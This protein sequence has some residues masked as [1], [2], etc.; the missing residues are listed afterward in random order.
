MQLKQ[1]IGM[2]QLALLICSS[3]LKIGF[4]SHVEFEI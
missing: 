1:R 3:W 4:I 2:D